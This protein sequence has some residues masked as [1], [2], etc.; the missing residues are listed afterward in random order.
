MEFFFAVMMKLADM[1]DLGSCAA[2][3]VGST[4]T[5][6]SEK[7]VPRS[8]TPGGTG[9]SFWPKRYNKI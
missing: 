9:F 5:D 7:P 1:Q 8:N 6:R 2:R 4:P 3:H